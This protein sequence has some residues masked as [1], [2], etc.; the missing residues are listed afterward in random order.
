MGRHC[1]F[2][3]EKPAMMFMKRNRRCDLGPSQPLQLESRTTLPA[4][5]IRTTMPL[6]SY[7]LKLNP[8]HLNET[9]TL[10]TLLLA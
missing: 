9:A 1:P 4:D 3:F 2:N 8:L 5:Q 7:P 10:H 6:T